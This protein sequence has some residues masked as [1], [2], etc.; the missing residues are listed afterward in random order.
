MANTKKRRCAA[1]VLPESVTQNDWRKDTK[2][3]P[4]PDDLAPALHVPFRQLAKAAER[5]I[6]AGGYLFTEATWRRDDGRISSAVLSDRDTA[7]VAAVLCVR[8][9]AGQEAVQA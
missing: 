5:F 4:L 6:G 8:D 9:E 2:N 7:T 3:R 1:G